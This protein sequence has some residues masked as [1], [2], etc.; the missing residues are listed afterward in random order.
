MPLPPCASDPLQPRAALA[1]QPAHGAEPWMPLAH[2]FQRDGA[3]VVR[4]VL[5]AG[6][7]ALLA[8]GI[9]ANLAA[10]SR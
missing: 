4:G 1:A 3:V 9:E 10:P 5:D 7:V 2:D 8:Q 6:E